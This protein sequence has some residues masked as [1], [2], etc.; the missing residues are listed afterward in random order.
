MSQK[1]RKINVV[2]R[3]HKF[4][5]L[6]LFHPFILNIRLKHCDECLMLVLIILINVS[7][8]GAANTVIRL[9]GNF[10]EKNFSNLI[11]TVNQNV[12]LKENCLF[13]IKNSIFFV[14]VILN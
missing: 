14:K 9:V 10:L 5:F 7:D 13:K 2:L 1:E 8:V 6:Q 12:H 3:F 11:V 4:Y